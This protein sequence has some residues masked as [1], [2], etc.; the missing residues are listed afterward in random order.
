MKNTIIILSG[1]IVATSILWLVD[2]K[3]PTKTGKSKSAENQKKN[4]SVQQISTTEEK[5]KAKPSSKPPVYDLSQK[6]IGAPPKQPAVY[7][8]E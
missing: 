5:A 4:E 7:T 6:H 1:A 2:E 3:L 8:E